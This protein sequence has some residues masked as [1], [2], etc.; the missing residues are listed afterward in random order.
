LDAGLLTLLAL[1]LAL[2]HFGVPLAYYSYLR[3]RWLSKPWGIAPDP[4][5]RPKVTVIVPTYNEAE[6]IESK[7]DNLAEG[8][9]TMLESEN[10]IVVLQ[11]CH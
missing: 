11:F 7:L 6:L 4:N 9:K 2:L 10:M 1:A 3:V 8:T 5:Y